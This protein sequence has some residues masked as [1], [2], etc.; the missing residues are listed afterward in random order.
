MNSKML[1]RI[2]CLT[3]VIALIFSFAACGGGNEGNASTEN[4]SETQKVKPIVIKFNYVNAPDDTFEW[5]KDLF[6]QIEEEA[7]GTVKF[8]CYSSEA[9]GKS[10][11]MVAAAAAGEPVIQQV[12]YTYFTDYCP[13]I[14]IFNSAY[15]VRSGEDYFKLVETDIY[16]ELHKKLEDAGLKVILQSYIGP[17]NLIINRE[18]HSR[19]DIVDAKVK[20]RCAGT[21]LWQD[22]VRILGGQPTTVA[23]SETYQALSQGVADGAENAMT[24]LNS[25]KFY[26]PCPYL[27]Q[28]E[29]IIALGTCVMSTE[30]YNSLPDVAQTAIDNALQT[31]LAFTI[32]KYKTYQAELKG[33]LEQNGVTFIEVDK[34]PF[35]EAATETPKLFPEWGDGY[36]RAVAELYGN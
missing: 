19:Q 22:I 27:I 33:Q 30:V 18:V 13:E 9:L 32:D 25:Y 28:T 10:I 2:L 36:E 14:G 35:I 5:Y 31:Y 21:P 24:Y 16:K 17:R 1:K 8:E 12:D 3:M 26:E 6:A 15:L 23:L 7:E 29:H 11:D 20:I 4:T 34:T